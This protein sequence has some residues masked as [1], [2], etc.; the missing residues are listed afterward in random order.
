MVQ[1]QLAGSLKVA[2]VRFVKGGTE[3]PLPPSGIQRQVMHAREFVG[4][5]RMACAFE[6]PRVQGS[7]AVTLN[8]NRRLP[9]ECLEG[10]EG[11]DK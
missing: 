6:S 10:R 11:L 9:F 3:V 8:Q 7:S 4:P 2:R 1:W 5:L